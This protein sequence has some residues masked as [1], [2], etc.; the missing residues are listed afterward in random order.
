MDTDEVG[1]ASTPR[2]GRKPKSMKRLTSLTKAIRKRLPKTPKSERAGGSISGSDS[3]SA[4]A[5]KLGS[6]SSRLKQRF[7]SSGAT[8]RRSFSAADLSDLGKSELGQ[9]QKEDTEDV[10]P[11]TDSATQSEDYFNKPTTAATPLDS[12]E[13]EEHDSKSN[14]FEEKKMCFLK[15]LF[16]QTLQHQVNAA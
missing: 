1:N 10:F 8:P 5:K 2:S 14:F 11:L 9:T 12:T 4:P 7:S 13:T 15:V 16:I 6:L 3:G